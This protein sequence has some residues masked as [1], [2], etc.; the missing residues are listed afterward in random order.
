MLPQG[1]ESVGAKQV[2]RRYAL[3]LL[4]ARLRMNSTLN[5]DKGSVNLF[6]VANME[7][8]D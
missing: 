2:V 5:V 7:S 6:I 4:N 1:L 8:T 3:D